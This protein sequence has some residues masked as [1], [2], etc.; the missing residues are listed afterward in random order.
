M[1]FLAILFPRF[2]WKYKGKSA[3]DRIFG[4]IEALLKAMAV[5]VGPHDMARLIS[6]MPLNETV[7]ELRHK[8]LV[9]EPT[10]TPYLKTFLLGMYEL[11]LPLLY[12]DRECACFWF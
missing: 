4:Q 8:C 12:C 9:L 6:S 3:A 11:Q 1:H 5:V 7:A 10:A 2:F